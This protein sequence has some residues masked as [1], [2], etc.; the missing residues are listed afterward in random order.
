[1][2]FFLCVPANHKSL[3]IIAPIF[4]RCTLAIWYESQQQLFPWN[5]ASQYQFG[6][7]SWQ[8]NE[9]YRS[10]SPRS[11]TSRSFVCPST[12][13]THNR[14]LTMVSITSNIC[15]RTFRSPDVFGLTLRAVE[16]FER[17]LLP[18]FF[19]RPPSVVSNFVSEI[20]YA[21]AVV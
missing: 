15:Q 1:M 7:Y 5:Y 12:C 20:C 4:A 14:N 10:G 11:S 16:S 19:C 6:W 13:S 18:F 8:T 9:Q 21:R 3:S 17:V 2:R